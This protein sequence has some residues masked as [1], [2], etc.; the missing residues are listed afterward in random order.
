MH[1]TPVPFLARAKCA[2]PYRLVSLIK[3]QQGQVD[4]DLQRDLLHQVTGH[5]S[6]CGAITCCTR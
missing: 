4:D 2:A 5:S 1:Q 6:L 3:E